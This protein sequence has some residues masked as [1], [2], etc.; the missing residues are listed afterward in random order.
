MSLSSVVLNTNSSVGASIAVDTTGSRAYQLVKLVDGTSGGTDGLPGSA[1]T[2]LTVMIHSAGSIG[3]GDAGGSLTVD[4]SILSVVGGGTEATAQR[5]TIASDSTGVLSVDDNGSSLTIDGTVAVSAVSGFIS[6]QS[7]GTLDTNPSDRALRDNGKVDI[8][9]F[10][11]GLPA[12]SGVDIGDVTINNASGASAVNIQDGGNSITIDGTITS[13][14]NAVT[15]HSAGSL[16]VTQSGT[17]NIGTVTTV[18]AVTAISNALPAGTNNIGDIDV[19]SIVPGTAATNLGKAEDAAHTT[20]DVGVMALAVRQDA[21]A[22]F[23]ADLDYSPLQLDDNGFLKVNIKAG[24]GSGGT[25]ST[26]DGAFTAGA[27]SGTPMMGFVT[28]DAV[29]SGDVGVVGMLANRQLKVTLY[30]SSGVELAVGGGTQYTED[31]AAAA[32]PVGNAL[33]LVR[34]DA[35]GG[36]LTTTDGDN[37]AARG[38]N[39]GELY[40]KHVDAIPVTDNGGALT[41]DGTVA[42]THAALT[43]L[44]TAIDTEMQCD[45]VGALPAGTNNIGDVDILSIAAG[46]N[47]IGDVD[48]ASIAAGTVTIGSVGSIGTVP[49]DGVD[50][51]SPIKIG[52]KAESSP[53]GIT[54]VADGDRT[55]AYSDLDGIQLVKLGTANAD[56]I[57]ESISDTGGSSTAFTQFSAVASTKN[58]VCGYSAFRTDAGTSL[59]YI[60]LRNGTAGAV[61]WRIP[62]PPNGGSNLASAIPIC[63]TSANTALAYDV[64]SALT[65]VYLSVF[66]FQS[67]A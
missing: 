35:R 63:S 54:L 28:A 56:L 42:V 10:D 13:I 22:A 46:N 7:T 39:A 8:A 40:V 17:W 19:L 67:K 34:E 4:N 33:I 44:A 27:G 6:L 15:I 38:T 26:D 48:I 2:G 30:D 9:A 45:I 14:T 43:E 49:H 58:Y 24:A 61:I 53:K 25:A 66:G 52:F 5:V 47:N 37:V 36:S 11:V 59:A 62:L 32:N 18:S 41:V 55:D 31:A 65:T 23:G 57:N 60:D 64:S 16:A 3:V 21:D 50:S 1:A 29:D 12:N 51:T 20:G